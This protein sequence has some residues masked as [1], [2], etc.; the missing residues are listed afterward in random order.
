MQ[1]IL[2][3]EEWQKLLNQLGAFVTNYRQRIVRYSNRFQ[4]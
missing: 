1:E 4:I 3:R 2:D